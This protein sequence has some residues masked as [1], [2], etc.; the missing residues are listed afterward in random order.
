MEASNNEDGSIPDLT[1]I[2]IRHDD[3]NKETQNSK[4]KKHS[5]N[6][7]K[8]K[9]QERTRDRKNEGPK[10]KLQNTCGKICSDI[11]TAL[12]TAHCFDNTQ[13]KGRL[14]S[15]CDTFH[16]ICLIIW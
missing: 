6:L 11:K 8:S 7:E 2:E 9:E 13:N 16:D 14:I 10:Q 4:L 15:R 3:G 12:N 1:E 5:H